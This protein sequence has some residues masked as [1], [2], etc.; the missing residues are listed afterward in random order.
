MGE[1]KKAQGTACSALCSDE[2]EGMGPA[3][4]A[5]ATRLHAPLS[6]HPLAACTALTIVVVQVPFRL[7]PLP[8]LYG[9]HNKASKDNTEE[10]ELNPAGVGGSEKGER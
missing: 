1:G 4:R 5:R 3:A 6:Q 10:L 8:L 7:L 2:R 9:L